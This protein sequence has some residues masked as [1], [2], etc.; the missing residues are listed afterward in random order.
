LQTIGSF[1]FHQDNAPALTA[2]PVREF[3]EKECIPMLPQAPYPPALSLCDFYLFPDLN[4]RVKGYHFETLDSVQKAVTDAIKT[5]TAAHF[6]SCYGAWKIRWA[7]RVALE[8][9]YSEGD[10]VDLDE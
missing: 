3:L 9:S 6:P 8:G 10:I 2:L 4:P 1:E 5:L 7:K